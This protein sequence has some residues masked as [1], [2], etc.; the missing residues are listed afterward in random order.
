VFQTSAHHHRLNRHLDGA[1]RLC[2][3]LDK[4]YTMIL[5]EADTFRGDAVKFAGDA[6][7]FMFVEEERGMDGAVRR[8]AACSSRVHRRI[9]SHPA[10]EGVKLTLHAGL[11][12][13]R[14]TCLAVGTERAEFVIAGPPMKAIGVAEPLAGPGET[15]ADPVAWRFLRDVQTGQEPLTKVH[16]LSDDALGFKKLD[17]DFS[18]DDDDDDESQEEGTLTP[19]TLGRDSQDL[20]KKRKRRL[21]DTVSVT[22]DDV[23]FMAPFIPP[24]FERVLSNRQSLQNYL[25]NAGSAKAEIRELT[26]CF[27]KI[28]GVDLSNLKEVDAS[29]AMMLTVQ[30]SVVNFGGSVN[31][32]LVDD[33]GTLAVLVF[34]LPGQVH[35]DSALRAVCAVLEIQQKGVHCFAGLTTGSTFA[36]VVGS[37][38][39]KEYTVMG[40]TVNL[41]AR[42]MASCITNFGAVDG[43]SAM[44]VCERTCAL[45][46]SDLEYHDMSPIHVKGK[47]NKVHVFIPEHFRLREPRLPPLDLRFRSRK[48]KR[49]QIDDV[50]RRYA[51]GQ[52][53]QTSPKRASVLVIVGVHGADANYIF[54]TIFDD[55]C[56]KH[57]LHLLP[58]LRSR[59][60]F[61][62]GLLQEQ[63]TCGAWRGPVLRAV[64]LICGLSCS[65]SE[66][67]SSSEEKHF[68][69]PAN[70]PIVGPCWGQLLQDN[71]DQNDDQNDESTFFVKQRQKRHQFA[72]WSD[73]VERHK[74]HA[75]RALH[76][77]EVRRKLKSKLPPDLVPH[78]PL[79]DDMFLEQDRVED[80][81][82][83]PSTPPLRDVAPALRDAYLA[84]LVICLLSLAAREK[85]CVVVLDNVT[86]MDDASWRCVYAIQEWHRRRTTTH[87]YVAPKV[88]PL[89][90]VSGGFSS[91]DS[92]SEPPLLCFRGFPL[93]LTNKVEYA[94]AV[95]Q[96]E[97][98]AALVE[99]GSLDEDEAMEFVAYSLGIAEED[100]GIVRDCDQLVKFARQADGKQRLLDEMLKEAQRFI[101]VV[102]DDICIHKDLLSLP[103][104]ARYKKLLLAQMDT[105]LPPHKQILIRAAA[106]LKDKFSSRMLMA[107]APFKMDSFHVKS[108]LE[109]QGPALFFRWPIHVFLSFELE[110]KNFSPHTGCA[111]RSGTGSTCSRGARRS[112]RTTVGC[113]FPRRTTSTTTSRIPWRGRR[114]RTRSWRTTCSSSWG[115]STSCRASAD[116]CPGRP[117]WCTRTSW[118]GDAAGTARRAA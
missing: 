12:A 29:Q 56:P 96:A 79:L 2:A 111:S 4:V 61:H 54:G 74:H 77:S 78:L 8:A 30:A 39:R 41:A 95:T 85:K 10:V 9:Q 44:V 47:K 45:T 62:D 97:E 7:L 14:I 22:A 109:Q 26:V 87:R 108:D 116:P 103:A 76:S 55:L 17:D 100:A 37:D 15:V 53:Q 105:D 48:L 23:K 5:D 57:G 90:Y 104:P 64:D 67:S 110:K 60:V 93:S 101:Q 82:I 35:D 32:L 69:Y 98:K 86:H 25:D 68:F 24:A 107:F 91:S 31:K 65:S 33:K 66:T 83:T 94:N 80:W 58:S 20:A 51:K 59:S 75:A 40:D 50:L 81:G 102:D 19:P 72:Q 99:I 106:S 114:W 43:Q 84:Q 1:E 38:R 36:G 52:Q 3:E 11:A 42:L 71:D 49:K 27:L 115:R 118:R 88:D 46:K 21:T 113:R 92:S 13:G 89:A 117:S 70:D 18:D 63:T 6:I 73:A 112:R 16:E 34:G 28:S